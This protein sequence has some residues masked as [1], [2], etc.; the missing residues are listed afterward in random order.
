[1]VTHRAQRRSLCRLAQYWNVYLHFPLGYRFGPQTHYIT[2]TGSVCRRVALRK[3]AL[4]RVRLPRID[5]HLGL[6]VE[7]ELPLAQA[8]LKL[9]AG[10]YILLVQRY[11][12]CRGDARRLGGAA[13]EQG[14]SMLSEDVDERSRE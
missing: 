13:A 4:R 11:R 7:Y 2:H 12:N 5:R 3:H 14:G 6:A 10:G 1:M 8:V 9:K